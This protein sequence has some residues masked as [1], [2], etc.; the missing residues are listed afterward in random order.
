MNI[1]PETRGLVYL[2]SSG[3]DVDAPPEK[4]AKIKV[5]VEVIGRSKRPHGSKDLAKAPKKKAATHSERHRHHHEKAKDQQQLDKK[6]KMEIA[7]H[8]VKVLV[9]HFKDGMIASK[10]VFKS[11]ARELTHV[12]LQR[13]DSLQK[14]FYSKYVSVFFKSSGIILNEEDAKKKIADFEASDVSK[15][16]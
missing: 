10:E 6:A 5:A 9:P 8:V 13:K 12:L 11:V 16:L 3:R 4:K 7:D 2:Q 15:A 14:G 1:P